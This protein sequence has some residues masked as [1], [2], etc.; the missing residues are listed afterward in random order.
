MLYDVTILLLQ[1][2]M[3]QKR[4]PPFLGAVKTVYFLG[5]DFCVGWTMVEQMSRS[6]WHFGLTEHECIN[7]ILLH[8]PIKD[9]EE[10]GRTCNMRRYTVVPVNS[11]ESGEFTWGDSS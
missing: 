5:M 3:L 9:K 11:S 7:C 1:P 2:H 4:C 10:I 8:Q 6:S